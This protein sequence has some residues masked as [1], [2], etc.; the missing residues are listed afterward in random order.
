M[1]IHTFR[2]G[3][4]FH[5]FL[6]NYRVFDSSIDIND[7]VLWRYRQI[8][9]SCSHPY[10]LDKSTI[11]SSLTRTLLV[12]LSLTLMWQKYPHCTRLN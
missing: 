9:N 2:W 4:G 5:I 7:G 12:N 10:H 3:Q 8:I 1:H 6:A 11:P